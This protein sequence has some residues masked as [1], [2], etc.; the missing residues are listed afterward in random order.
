MRTTI[1]SGLVAIA[2]LLAACASGGKPI[3]YYTIEPTAPAPNQSNPDGPVISVAN[4][5]IPPALQDGRIRYRPGSN[6][7]GAYEY[8]RWV[9]SPGMMV[10][11]ALVRELRASGKYQRVLE[12][13]SM[14]AADYLLR[15]RLYEFAEADTPA[16]QTRISLHLELLDRKTNRHL[17]D[18]VF[19]G[20]DP[21]SGKT[22]KEVV[23]SMDRN[24]HQVVRQA[25]GEI[26]GILAKR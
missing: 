1:I 23:Q 22:I 8:H 7:V 16:I 25:V 5:A 15:G 24:L 17:W 3:H 14:A 12:S 19:D 4:I 6:E 26:D 10:R 9:A 13:S 2:C 21:V 20:Q 18:R 11:D